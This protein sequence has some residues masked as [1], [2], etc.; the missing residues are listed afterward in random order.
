MFIKL[1]V[2]WM[3]AIMEL[4]S[5]AG[6]APVTDEPATPAPAPNFYT[7][8]K[9]H[10]GHRIQGSWGNQEKDWS[11][12]ISKGEVWGKDG[13]NMFRGEYWA[14]GDRQIRFHDIASTLMMCT[15]FDLTFQDFLREDTWH[16]IRLEGGTMTLDGKLTFTRL[17]TSDEVADEY[18]PTCPRKA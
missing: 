5:L 3:V 8:P 12:T 6:G 1:L 2:V 11:I 9:R 17:K 10:T 13:C 14:R 16:D 7:A 15:P 4:A 18:D